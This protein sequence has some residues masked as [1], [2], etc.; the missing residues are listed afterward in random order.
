MR[1]TQEHG[2][3]TKVMDWFDIRGYFGIKYD[4]NN[5]PKFL[6]SLAEAAVRKYPDTEVVLAV[7]EIV[8]SLSPDT[9]DGE[10]DWTG[11]NVPD[12]VSLV[13]AFNP[14]FIE[15][16]IK[17]P[18]DDSYVHHRCSVRYRSTISITRMVD[19]TS[20]H[21]GMGENFQ[22]DLAT[23]ILGEKP[24]VFDLGKVTD[25]AQVKIVMKQI[26]EILVDERRQEITVIHTPCFKYFFA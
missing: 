20:Q 19:C 12:K 4:N 14:R 23:D 17:L 16:P 3:Q 13:L 9:E 24:T 22:G 25:P 26:E 18:Q 11:L 7:D 6:S 21:L 8:A 5:L 15:K 1:E 10:H 2:D